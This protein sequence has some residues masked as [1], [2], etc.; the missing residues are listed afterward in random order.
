MEITHAVLTTRKLE[1]TADYYERVLA[2]HTVR[3]PGEVTVAV[4]ST[5]LVF[6]ED[7]DAAGFT[8]LA[9]TVPTGS[10]AAARQWLEQRT[11]LL[12]LG[13]D[14]EFAGPPNWN[15]HSLYFDGPDGSIL[16]LIERRDLA[17]AVDAEFGPEQLLCVSE[18]GVAVPDVLETVRQLEPLGVLPYAS[19]PGESFAPVGDVNGLLI[20]VSPGR[21]WFPTQARPAELARVKVSLPGGRVLRF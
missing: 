12:D 14:V 18:V 16:E 10:F 7:T 20:L 17:N 21:P 4:G 6:Q 15:S 11:R 3:E 19:P 9:F 2:L 8:H 13:G 1:E 5:M